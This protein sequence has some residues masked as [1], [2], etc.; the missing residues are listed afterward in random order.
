MISRGSSA[1]WRR[2]LSP[3]LACHSHTAGGA[4]ETAKGSL[5]QNIQ[6]FRQGNQAAVLMGLTGHKCTDP[7]A[8]LPVLCGVNYVTDMHELAPVF[9]LNSSKGGLFCKDKT[10]C[11]EF[12]PQRKR[13]EKSHVL[14]II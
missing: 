2:K 14:E 10:A 13:K 11:V 12:E 6:N 5:N 1:C 3:G 8:N 7:T 4:Q 9:R